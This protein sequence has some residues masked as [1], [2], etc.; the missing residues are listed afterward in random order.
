MCSIPTCR[1]RL[2]ERQE[3]RLGAERRP[4]L[5]PAEAQN[6][7]AGFGG[8]FIQLSSNLDGVGKQRALTRPVEV[9]GEES[10]ARHQERNAGTLL[11]KH[12]THLVRIEAAARLRNI[13]AGVVTWA[14]APLPA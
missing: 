4:R 3:G 13:W 9:S 5:D 6:I 10:R 12:G 7:P 2:A 1:R 8:E 11:D 14:A